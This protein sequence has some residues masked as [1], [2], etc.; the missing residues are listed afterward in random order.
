VILTSLFIE[1]SPAT[2]N[3]FKAYI[4]YGCDVNCGLALRGLTFPSLV[5]AVTKIHR[6]VIYKPDP[7]PGLLKILILAGADVSMIQPYKHAELSS[8]ETEC[9]KIISDLQT[10][11]QSL[12]HLSRISIR[13]ILRTN[14]PGKLAG[15]PGLPPLL[16]D[17]LLLPEIDDIPPPVQEKNE[18]ADIFL[19]C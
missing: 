18:A 4:R 9:Q 10:R 3:V 17:Y 11:P 15:L 16:K 14:I 7:Y 19:D 12:Q 13:N 2:Y 6:T 8:K 1:W 5:S